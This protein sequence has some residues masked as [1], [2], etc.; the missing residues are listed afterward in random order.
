MSRKGRDFEQAVYHFAK[1]LDPGAEVIFDHKV[2]DRDS[3]SLR[4]CDVW[5]NAKFAD[6]WPLSILV[7]CKKH[8]R[9][10]DVS[11]VGAFINEKNSTGAS[12]GVIYSK[13]GFTT[14]ALLKCK[15]N[16]IVCCQLYG[17]ESANL[18]QSI[19]LEQFICKPSL[20]HFSLVPDSLRKTYGTWNEVFDIL[21]SSNTTQ[22]VL[23]VIAAKYSEAEHTVVQEA[24]QSLSFPSDWSL[25]LHFAEYIIK[26]PFSI[27]IDASWKRYKARIEANLVNGS[28]CLTNDSFMGRITGPSFDTHNSHPGDGWVE[29]S[30][31]DH[32]PLNSVFMILG[33]GQNIKGFLRETLGPMRILQEE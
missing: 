33:V 9:K 4:Q 10:L 2:R 16:G 24:E 14:N 29:V 5:I 23:D 26:Q 31:I 15:A 1:T 25:T 22:T 19:F 18:P 17:D 6:H 11:H 7:S 28:Y 13:S 27:L 8:G 30:G 20:A 12:A 32:R 3:N 21:I